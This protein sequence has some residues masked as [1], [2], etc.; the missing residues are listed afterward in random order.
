MDL[1]QLAKAA[2][3]VLRE[4][5][6]MVRSLPHPKVYTKEG[7]ANFVTEADLASQKFLFQHLEPLLPGAHFFAE[8][9]KEHKMEPGY[10]WV[11]DPIDGTTNFM[12]GYHPWAISVGL[13]R[14]GEGV[15]G[16]VRTR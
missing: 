15:L 2:E 4:D 11:I 5:G 6:A 8:E 16:L 3:A 1:Q 7:H 9:Q 10:N 12:R 13:V 14:D